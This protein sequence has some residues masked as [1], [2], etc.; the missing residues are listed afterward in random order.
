[1][2]LKITETVN[3]YNAKPC[4]QVYRWE[5]HDWCKEGRWSYMT[6]FG[7]VDEA[8]EFMQLQIKLGDAPLPE[9]L[10]EEFE[11]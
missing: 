2:K 9:K 3:R 10:V 11:G 1:M 5:T 8:R 4:F 7:T 6:S